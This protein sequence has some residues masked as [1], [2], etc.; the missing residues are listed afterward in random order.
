MPLVVLRGADIRRV[1]TRVLA[2]QHVLLASARLAIGILMLLFTSLRGWRRE[3][4]GLRRLGPETAGSWWPIWLP[5]SRFSWPIALPVTARM[6]R[7]CGIFAAGASTIRLQ[8]CRCSRC[9]V[10]CMACIA[11][12]RLL[13]DQQR[14]PHRSER[15]EKSD[16]G[17]QAECNPTRDK[18]DQCLACCIGRQCNQ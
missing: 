3:S 16:T 12:P 9:G 5:A 1:A 4:G 18:R 13:S 15:A 17:P 7:A 14:C 11:L 6:V 8:I 10:P 2:V